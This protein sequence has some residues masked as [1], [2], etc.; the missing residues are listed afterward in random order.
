MIGRQFIRYAAIGLGLNVAL[1]G[2]YLLLT[3]S[4]LGSRAAMTCTYCTGVLAGFLLNRRVTFRYH[5][6]NFGALL[7]YVA[8][9]VIGYVINFVTLVI[10]VDG[11]DIA[12]ERVQGGV[13]LTLP[14]LLFALQKYWVFPTPAGNDFSFL[15]RSAP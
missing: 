12:H 2:A 13:I 5:G 11:A 14:V 1:Y 15:T 6:G 9:Y 4:L 3:Y 8:T 7:R 10:F